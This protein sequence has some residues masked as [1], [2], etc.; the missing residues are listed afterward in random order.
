[1][2]QRTFGDFS[3]S[4]PIPSLINAALKSGNILKESKKLGNQYSGE[5]RNQ[6]SYV[7][8]NPIPS[9]QFLDKDNPIKVSYLGLEITFKPSKYV[10]NAD[11][12]SKLKNVLGSEVIKKKLIQEPIISEDV[13]RELFKESNWDY[14]FNYS[15][16]ILSSID[17]SKLEKSSDG[18]VRVP[19][20]RALENYGINI[21]NEALERV[22]TVIKQ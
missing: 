9:F 16:S 15:K 5:S 11:E 4:Q 14:Y 8:G 1:M 20:I 17:P 2:S 21:L 22:Y 13:V 7:I 12:L 18:Y 6:F 3:S 10:K 19:G